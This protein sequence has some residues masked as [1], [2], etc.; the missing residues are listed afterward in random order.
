MSDYPT[1]T[2]QN[3]FFVLC[4]NAKNFDENLNHLLLFCTIRWIFRWNYWRLFDTEW[5]WWNK[6]VR[7][8]LWKFYT[9]EV[10]WVCTFCSKFFHDQS[11]VFNVKVKPNVL[12]IPQFSIIGNLVSL[13]GLNLIILKTTNFTN[14]NHHIFKIFVSIW[15]RYI[16][17]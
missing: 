6:S 2:S 12:L 17:I 10:S 1:S 7:F 4:K 9:S 5:N 3:F 14:I 8:T 11:F 15:S 13:L 16:S